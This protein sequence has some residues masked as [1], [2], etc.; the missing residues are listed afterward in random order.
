MSEEKKELNEAE[1][2]KVNGG[3]DLPVLPCLVYTP[4][5]PDIPDLPHGGTAFP[6]NGSNICAG[7]RCQRYD[8]CTFSI[9]K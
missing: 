7:S 1:L 2:D 9:K 5:I 6:C 4:D 8:S 3:I